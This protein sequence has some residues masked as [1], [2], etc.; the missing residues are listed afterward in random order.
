MVGFNSWSQQMGLYLAKIRLH[1]SDCPLVNTAGFTAQSQ[2]KNNHPR[3]HLVNFGTLSGVDLDFAPITR[4]YKTCG[5][6][7]RN[8]AR[9][10]R[11]T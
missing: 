2:V 3:S 10:S 1:N 8:F 6:G 11:T 9:F 5:S 7:V 4:F